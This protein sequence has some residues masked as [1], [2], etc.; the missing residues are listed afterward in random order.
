MIFL[1]ILLLLLQFQ[2]RQTHVTRVALFHIESPADVSVALVDHPSYNLYLAM[3]SH[4]KTFYNEA[5]VPSP[6]DLAGILIEV[7]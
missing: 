6:C 7:F 2:I 1:F 5:P 3:K 4:M